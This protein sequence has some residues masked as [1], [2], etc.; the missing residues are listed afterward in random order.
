MKKRNFLSQ[1]EKQQQHLSEQYEKSL[2]EQRPLYMDSGDISMLADWHFFHKEYSKAF[3]MVDHGLRLHPDN[4][5]LLRRK[6][7]LY[8]DSGYEPSVNALIAQLPPDDDTCLLRARMAAN[9]GDDDEVW[10]ILDSIREKDD[11]ITAVEAAYICLEV[12]NPQK[13][14]E[15]LNPISRQYGDEEPFLSAMADASYEMG[16]YEEAAGYYNKLID[17]DPYVPSYWYGLARCYYQE[18]NF[19]QAIDACNYALIGD[20]E[21]GDA[22]AMRGNAYHQLGNADAALE[23]YIQAVKRDA[24]PPENVAAYQG[25]IAMSNVDWDI[26]LKYMKEAIRESETCDG[27]IY[28][29]A[30]LYT[31]A[32]K[33]CL[34]KGD[35]KQAYRYCRKALSLNDTEAD[36]YLIEGRVCFAQGKPD[37]GLKLWANALAVSPNITTWYDVGTNFMEIGDVESAGMAFRKVAEEDINYEFVKE[38]LAVVSL[39]EG[40][41]AQFAHY[42]SLF[43]HPFSEQ[44]V[45]QIKHDMEGDRKDRIILVIKLIMKRLH[46]SE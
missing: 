8:L 22:Y 42:N 34:N 27:D 4:D 28:A 20:D 43:E 31:Q 25:L 32:A 13:A 6:A 3:E 17:R 38:R 35:L 23:N 26:A 18:N 30:T 16:D 1:R 21:Y 9:C 11:L 15:W 19:E 5:E 37:K 45:E 7:Y 29:R 36:A 2:F 39:I 24:L 44:E 46:L 33:C 40:D 10:S 41:F 12:E 14:F